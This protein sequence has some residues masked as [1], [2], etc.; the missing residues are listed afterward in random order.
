M[1]PPS[2]AH[3]LGARARS[4]VSAALRHLRDAETLMKGAP[5]DAEHLAT[6]PSPDG[7]FYLAGYAPELIR[8]ATLSESW[9]NRAIGHISQRPR[10]HGAGAAALLLATELDPIAHR[11]AHRDLGALHDLG[12]STDARY[13]ATGTHEFLDAQ[14][15]LNE[16]RR[17]TDEI[18]VDM[19]ADGRF[20]EGAVPW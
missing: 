1:A 11:Y 10:G 12:W 13:E 16:A 3:A 4:F 5:A 19:W 6:R 17:I 9:L 2:S 20:V 14:E 18:V 15:I 8:K 7:A